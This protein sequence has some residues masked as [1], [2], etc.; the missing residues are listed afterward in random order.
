MHLTLLSRSS[1]IYT[2]R[3]LVEAA[4]ARGHKVRV[5]DPLE[6]E[7]GL[8]G[9][10]ALFHRQRALPRTDVIVPRIGLSVTQYGLSV[11]NQFELLGVPSLNRAHGIA[12]SRNKMRCLQTLA[13]SGVQ[14]PRTV[15]ASDASKLRDLVKH[16]GGVPVLV[17]L[18]STGD[19][20]GV[21]VCET[22]ESLEAAL[23]AILGLGQNIL[24]QQYLRGKRGQDLRALVVGGRVVAA[25]RRRARAGRFARSLAQ[26]A[27]FEPAALDAGQERAALET[28]RI[29][30]LDVCAVDLLD[31]REGP[32]VFEVNSSPGIRDAEEACGVDVAA[33]VVAAAEALVERSPRRRGVGE[34][35]I[36]RAP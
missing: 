32:L 26:G 9:R 22:L 3:R 4:R 27:R 8:G 31:T 15:M 7:L 19:K 5:L 20:G 1:A 29:V 13:G 18:V 6:V 28:A 35:A 33:A 34:R 30:G 16:V 11:V 36:R 2:T 23:E 25:L 12:A 17:K 14:V 24:V 10:P 21:M